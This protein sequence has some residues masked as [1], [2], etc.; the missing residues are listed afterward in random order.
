MHTFIKTVL[1]GALLTTSTLTQADLIDFEGFA[2]GTIIDSE[3]QASHG[4]TIN[5]VNVDRGVDGMATIFD[6]LSPTGGDTDLAGPFSNPLLGTANPGNVLIIH[7]HPNECNGLICNDPDDEGS[8][9]AG[10]FE[11]VFGNAVTLNSIDFFDIEGAENGTSPNNLIQLFDEF[12]TEISPTT[13]YTPGT[14]GDNTWGR[15]NFT[16]AGVSSIHL[17]LG[18]SGAIDNIRYERGTDQSEGAEAPAPA[19]PALLLLGALALSQVRRARAIA[20]AHKGRWAKATALA[21]PY[22]R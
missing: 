20:R 10:Y 1:T 18:G 19:T 14:G 17:R 7:E 16:A 2:V 13:F 11:I 5:G 8:R 6:T 22:A 15:L 12:S 21:L 9:P 3:Y 4:V